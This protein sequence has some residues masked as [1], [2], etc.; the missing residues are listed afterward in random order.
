MKGWLYILRCADNS[1]YVGSTNNLELR[2]AQHA[3]GEGSQYTRKRLPF[4]LVF[5]QEFPSEHDAFLRERQVKGWSRAK[6]EA[7]I[8]EDF[9]ALI[10]LAKSKA[11]QTKEIGEEEKALER[12]PSAGSG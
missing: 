5:A 9:D 1:Y 12:H 6:K 2:L 8:R 4:E 3:A 10:M 7:L 11:S